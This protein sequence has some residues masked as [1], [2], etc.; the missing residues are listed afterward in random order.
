MVDSDPQDDSAPTHDAVAIVDDFDA[1]SKEEPASAQETSLVVVHE[2][3]LHGA[4]HTSMW[5]YFKLYK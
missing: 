1:Q 3:E 5:L 2:E 4:E